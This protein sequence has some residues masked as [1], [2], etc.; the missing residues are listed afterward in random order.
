MHNQSPNINVYLM[1]MSIYFSR[2][3]FLVLT[4]SPVCSL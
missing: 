4:K 2:T 3:I 1:V